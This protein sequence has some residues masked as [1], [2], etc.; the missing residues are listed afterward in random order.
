MAIAILVAVAL[1]GLLGMWIVR[2]AGYV[3]IAYGQQIIE[4]SLWVALAGLVVVYLLLRGMAYIFHRLMSSQSQVMNWRSGRK[5]NSARQLTVKGMLLMAEGRWRDGKKALLSAVPSVDTPLINYLQA[6]R[7]AHELGDARERDDLL[8]LAHESTPG[9]EFAATLTQAEF[10]MSDGRYEQALAALLT[11]Q[12]RAPKHKTVLIMLTGCYEALA[13]WQALHEVLPETTD[14]KAISEAEV[15]RLSRLVWESLLKGDEKISVLWK[16]L[17]RYL[18]ED[19]G[20]LQDWVEHLITNGRDDDAE[21]VVTLTLDQVWIPELVQRY[22]ILKTSE[23]ERQLLVAQ[24]W[25]KSRPNDPDLLLCLGRLSLL[26]EE[27]PQAREY[28][29]AALRWSPSPDVYAELGRLCVALGDE[30]RGKDYL[31]Q[32]LSYLPDLPLPQTPTIRG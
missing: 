6:A 10:Q 14:R 19:H 26:C 32:S 4:T 18:K 13:D 23:P 17:P 30:R 27:F 25:S 28:F 29:D 1:G 8:R 12:K 21:N 24:G 5:A 11:L 3:L 22:G 16:R 7:S 31:L 9:A 15:R 2:D 20:L